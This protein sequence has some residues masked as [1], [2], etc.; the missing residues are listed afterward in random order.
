MIAR[1]ALLA[2]SVLLVAALLGSCGEDEPAASRDE[3]RG[4]ISKEQYVKR[5]NAICTRVGERSKSLADETLGGLPSPPSKE[6][7]RSYQRR[8]TA[9]Q[10]DGLAD[11]RALPAPERDERRLEEIY[12]ALERVIDGLAAIP[13]DEPGSS[14]GVALERFRRLAGDYGLTECARGG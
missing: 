1:Q 13:A 11:L 5:A 6:L 8:A 7:D 2:A 9:I 10:R 12:D 4:N 3:T 14:R